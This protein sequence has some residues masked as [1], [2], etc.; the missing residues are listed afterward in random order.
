[1]G[2]CKQLVESMQ[3]QAE[4]RFLENLTIG[5]GYTA[6]YTDDGGIGVAYTPDSKKGECS[7]LPPNE[8]YEGRPASEVLDLLLS[9]RDL[10]R[11]IGLA[12]INALNHA[13]AQKLPEDRDNSI[14]FDT[15]GID[16]GTKVAMVGHFAPIVARLQ[17]RGAQV[18]FVDRGKGLGDELQFS[19][20]LDS[21]A[22][23]A[24][25]TSTSIINNTLDDLL[26]SMSNDVRVALMGP[27][28][29]LLK[30]PF[31]ENVRLLAGTVPMDSEAT[32]R[33]VRQAKGTP[34]IQKFSK[35]TLLVL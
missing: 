8:D 34:V 12:L 26:T 14:M 24:I 16:Q 18:E 21:W 25:V 11:A 29:P 20:R 32:L 33:A 31:Q 5:L 3:E 22:E 6:V 15:L 1:M 30:A 35:K 9:G 4:G 7:V 13:Q 17:E 10:H 19:E 28:T 23:V 2:I 27:S